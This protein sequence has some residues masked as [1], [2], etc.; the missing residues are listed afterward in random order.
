[1]CECKHV[2]VHVRALVLSSVDPFIEKKKKEKVA[3][4]NLSKRSEAE[5]GMTVPVCT[6]ARTNARTH[7][8][9]HTHFKSL[10]EQHNIVA[11]S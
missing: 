5:K 10:R 4:P 7:A 9:V 11:V 2:R 3:T 1:M 6:H 8:R